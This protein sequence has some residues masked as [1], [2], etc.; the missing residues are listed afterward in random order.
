ME[1]YKLCYYELR[2]ETL[3]ELREDLKNHLNAQLTDEQITELKELKEK[4]NL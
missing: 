2:P 1:K 3:K 4:L